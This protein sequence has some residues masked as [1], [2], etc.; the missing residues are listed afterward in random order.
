MKESS[1]NLFWETIS[2]TSS[3]TKDYW[4]LWDL[5]RLKHGVLECKWEKTDVDGHF[6]QTVLPKKQRADVM[7]KVHNNLTEG[8]LGVKKS[9]SHLQQ[10]F[11][12]VGMQHDVKEWCCSSDS[13]V[14]NED[15]VGLFSGTKFKNL[16]SSKRYVL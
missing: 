12:W 4:S 16:F 13:G 11:Y 5:L 1:V 8:H 7:K 15:P 2:A 14:R 10:R 9:L 6:W 3:A